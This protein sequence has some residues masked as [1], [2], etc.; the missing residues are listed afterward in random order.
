MPC[1]PHDFL[2]F[3]ESLNAE[4][5]SSVILRT[6]ISRSYYGMYHKALSVLTKEP[7]SYNGKGVHA[8]LIEYYQKDISK[9]ES[10]DEKKS[11][12]L[13][14][15]LKQGR[16]LRTKSDYKLEE[17]ITKSDV[18]LSINSAKRFFEL[19]DDLKS[20]DQQRTA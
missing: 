8:S 16:D 2:D 3:A 13:S 17:V 20:T 9:D 18:A 14:Y 19:C 7:R 1:E 15:M 10:F 5:A 4:D 11:R 12:R 6:I